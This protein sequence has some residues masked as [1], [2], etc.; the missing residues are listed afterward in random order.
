MSNNLVVNRLIINTI[1]GKIA[2]D[3]EFHKGI[4][5]IRGDNSSGKSTITHFLFYVLGGAFN[6]WVKE[7]R[8]CSDVMAEIEINGA[9]VTL[10]RELNFNEHTGKSNDKEALR[11][12]WGNISDALS[13][14]SSEGW[15]KYGFNTTNDIKSFSNVLF[16]NLE[17]PIVKGDNNITMHQI[18]RLLYLDQ[19]SPTSS[20]FLYEQ[21]DSSLTRETVSN[22]LLGVYDH[23]IYERKQRKI[24]VENELN[25]V[26][27]E[28]RALKKFTENKL[29]L[30]PASVLAKIDNAQTEINRI[31][32]SI[33]ELSEKNKSVRYSEKTMLEFEKL[34][35]ESISEREQV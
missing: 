15:H 21:F 13:S 12:F 11:I 33:V 7:A 17:I 6:N 29:D 22:L 3:E 31:D 23:E 14:H 10:K 18:L 34:N 26:K 1:D 25:D 16:E 28:I 27:R 9:I 5:I 4:N 32:N 24:E 30:E 8:K 20:L 19:D 35:M 2:Y